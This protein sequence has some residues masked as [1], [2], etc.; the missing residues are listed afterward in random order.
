LEHLSQSI[1]A[2]WALYQP[3]VLSTRLFKSALLEAFTGI[4]D[5]P[6]FCA[7]CSNFCKSSQRKRYW[8]NIFKRM[9]SS[10]LLSVFF[11]SL[12][13]KCFHP[14]CRYLRALAALYIRMTFRAV[15]VYELLEPLLKDYRKLRQRNMGSYLLGI[16]VNELN[17]KGS[18]RRLCPDFHG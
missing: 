2:I 17:V 15:E 13:V 18:L 10:G 5:L 9:N 11:F 12:S 6:N 16:F 14:S 4:R 7:F 3:K 8:W 1:T